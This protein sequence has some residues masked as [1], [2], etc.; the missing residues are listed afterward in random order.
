MKF[1]N[2][3]FSLI[4]LLLFMGLFTIILGVLTNLFSVIIDTQAEIESTS[5]VENDSKYITTR[6]MYDI[7]RAQSISVPASLGAQTSTLSLIIDGNV[8]QY[9]VV[10]GNLMLT[11]NSQSDMLNTHVTQ[12]TNLSFQRF[13]NVGGKNAVQ[14]RMT[15]E[16]RNETAAGTE[17]KD[18]ETVIGLR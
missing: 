11:A 10:D 13:G 6:L 1:H 12:V 14:L 7:Q 16:D 9:S 3:G 18:I 2:K 15:L 4:E 17:S 5:A 8:V